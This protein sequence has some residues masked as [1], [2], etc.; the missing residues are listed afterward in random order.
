[1]AY[2][3]ALIHFGKAVAYS[4]YPVA[5]I[6][7]KPGVRSEIKSS[8]VACNGIYG[9]VFKHCSAVGAV[10]AAGGVLYYTVI[11]RSKPK[12]VFIVAYRCVY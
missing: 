9:G 5:F 7:N 10:K 11:G 6:N 8:F 12:I 4:G 2:S 3:H 1:M